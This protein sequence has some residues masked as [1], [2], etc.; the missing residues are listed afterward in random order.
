MVVVG[1]FQPVFECLLQLF[2]G[3]ASVCRGIVMAAG[4]GIGKRGAWQRVD[5]GIDATEKSFDV[6]A[7]I[8]YAGRR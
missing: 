2:N 7:G 6:R 1:M 3:Q 4:R 8:G 5:K